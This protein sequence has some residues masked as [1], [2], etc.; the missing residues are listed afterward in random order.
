MSDLPP[1]NESAEE[2][3]TKED[4]DDAGAVVDDSSSKKCTSFENPVMPD[5]PPGSESAEEATTKED[6][7]DADAFIDDSS[8]KKKKR[9]AITAQRNV[10]LF[11]LARF[12]PSKKASTSKVVS[13][14]TSTQETS[15]AS[16]GKEKQTS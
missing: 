13:T 11:A 2:A 7:D 8:T 4:D 10:S 14:S 6:D 1:G 15:A 5:L 12:E 9:K 16:I 3:T